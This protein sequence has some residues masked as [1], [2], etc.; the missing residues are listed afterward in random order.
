MKYESPISYH[1]KDIPDVKVFV[2]TKRR[3]G[4]KLYAPIYRYGDIKINQKNPQ[5]K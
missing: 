3:T 4:Q 5:A 1:S 2:E